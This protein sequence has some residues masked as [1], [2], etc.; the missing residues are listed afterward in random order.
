M[1]YRSSQAI[2]IATALTGW[3]IGVTQ[4]IERLHGLSNE[5]Y[6][7]NSSQERYVIRVYDR[8][9]TPQAIWFEHRLL[10]TL[11]D[12]NLP[13]AI[14]S[15]VPCRTG[16]TI[17]MLPN[18]RAMAVFTY[19]DGSMPDLGNVK[20]AVICG[21][22]LGELIREMAKL[23]IGRRDV[24][25]PMC[26]ELNRLQPAINDP[27]SFVR[28][29]RLEQREAEVLIDTY[30][31]LV[32]EVPLMYRLLP[33]QLIH[34]DFSPTNVLIDRQ[35]RKVVGVLDF[36][37]ATWDLRALDLSTAIYRFI[38][39][40]LGSGQE[41]SV[42]LG[43]ARAFQR[44]QELEDNEVEWIPSLLRLRR[45]ASILHWVGRLYANL[46]DETQVREQLKKTLTLVKWLS[47][48]DDKVRDLIREARR[49]V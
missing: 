42:I 11:A 18:G 19:I 49:A 5:T 33:M 29:L 35:W 38:A 41:W 39:P 8:V 13:Y 37:F 28:K 17:V 45:V 15:A 7:V 47:K 31:A 36:E 9:R 16:E 1:E 14:P 10:S 20:H 4:S 26:G 6:L 2:D 34:G 24:V 25:W 48:Y 44:V 43:F 40:L 3:G 32:N 22:A 23:T 12:R 21:K 30:T 46:A 27:V